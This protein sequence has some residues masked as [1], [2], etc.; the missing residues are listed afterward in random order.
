[1][2]TA[3]YNSHI[4]EDSRQTDLILAKGSQKHQVKSLVNEDHQETQYFE[5][6]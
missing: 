4:G 5:I 6:S 3:M 2:K 1:M